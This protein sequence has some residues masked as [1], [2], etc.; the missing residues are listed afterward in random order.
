MTETKAREIVRALLINVQ[1]AR[2]NID[3]F[4][5]WF[6]DTAWPPETIAWVKEDL[7]RWLF[8]ERGERFVLLLA[9]LDSGTKPLEPLT[10]YN[11]MVV[12]HKLEP[13]LGFVAQLRGWDLPEPDI[14]W[15]SG[16]EAAA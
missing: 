5:D 2:S 16:F 10:L 13:T 8:G 11:L 3:E 15:L 7:H 6:F 14:E 4:W 9:D 12:A 1:K